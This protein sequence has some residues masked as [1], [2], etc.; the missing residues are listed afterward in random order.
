MTA[1]EAFPVWMFVAPACRW[2]S[3][4]PPGGENRKQQKKSIPPLPEYLRKNHGRTSE[5][6]FGW[7]HHNKLFFL[8]FQQSPQSHNPH[9]RSKQN[10]TKKDYFFYSSKT[11]QETTEYSSGLFIQ[12]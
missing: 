4:S 1:L 11:S 12:I 8:D 7:S 5:N 6:R 9:P 2:W 3:R 10:E